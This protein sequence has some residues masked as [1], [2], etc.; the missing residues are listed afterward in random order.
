MN[1]SNQN[2]IK[3]IVSVRKILAIIITTIIQWTTLKISRRPVST[4]SN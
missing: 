1:I 4:N 3:H 2:V